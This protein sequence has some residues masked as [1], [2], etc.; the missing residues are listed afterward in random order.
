MTTMADVAEQTDAN[1]FIPF[2]FLREDVVRKGEYS[3]I[4]EK[5]LEKE[6]QA[7]KKVVT[8]SSVEKINDL[9]R[10]ISGV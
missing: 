6:I 2:I 9:Q 7:V 10:Q 5:A 1:S 8:E 4:V 3:R